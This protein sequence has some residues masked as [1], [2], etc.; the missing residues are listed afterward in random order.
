MPAPSR[1]PPR[2][3]PIEAWITQQVADAQG[4]SWDLKGLWLSLW[5]YR[6]LPGDTI[7]DRTQA[8]LTELLGWSNERHLKWCL[9]QARRYGMLNC[10]AG[11]NGRSSD[12]VLRL[13]Y[14]WLT[15]PQARPALHPPRRLGP[16]GPAP[17]ASES[18]SEP[19]GLDSPLGLLVP[20]PFTPHAGGAGRRP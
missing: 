15:E 7:P 2:R 5:S 4:P 13:P 9:T 3:R 10:H 6:T 1:R 14:L 17:E 16:T 12:Y 11:H 18:T 8:Q 20:Q 19:D